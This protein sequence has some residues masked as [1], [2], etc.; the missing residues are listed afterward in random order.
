MRIRKRK[1]IKVTWEGY[2]YLSEEQHRQRCESGKPLSERTIER[3][4]SS[5]ERYG[6]LCDGDRG[7][8]IGSPVNAWE[9]G[10]WTDWSVEDMKRMLDEKGFEWEDVG[11]RESIEISI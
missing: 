1:A 4:K 2:L 5:F 9:E 8:C 10:R 6:I 3:L 7:G 11:E